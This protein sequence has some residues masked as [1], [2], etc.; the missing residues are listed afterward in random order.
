[1]MTILFWTLLTFG[2]NTDSIFIR[3]GGNWP[4]VKKFISVA[5]SK[6]YQNWAEFLLSAMPDVDLVNLNSDDFIRYFNA[7]EKNYQRVP[8]R[9]KIDTNLFYYY[10]LPHRVSQEPLENFNAFYCDTLYE[11]IKKTKDMR[12]AVL[13]INEW[14]Y[15]KM[16]YEPTERWDQNAITTIKRGIGRCEEMSILFI[17]ALRTVCI[18]ARHTYTPWWPFT[19]SN[20]AWVEVWTEDGWHALGGGELTD[21]DQAWFSTP[22]QRAAIIKS[23]MYGNI[24]ENDKSQKLNV[25]SSASKFDNEIIDKQGNG[26]TIIN[27][28]PNY[29]DVVDLLIK[30]TKDNLPVESASVSISVYNYS[31]LA[32]VGVKKT[33]ENGCVQ[34]YVGKTDLFIYAYKDSQIG[35]YVWRS[36]NKKR[37][38]VVIDIVRREFPDTSF[39]LYTRKVTLKNQKSKYRPNTELLRKLQEEHFI[40]INSLDSLTITKLDS[41]LIRIFKDA[42]GNK[43]PLMEFY[44]KL[45]ETE[46]PIFKKYFKN[47]VQKDIVGLDTCGLYQELLAV[48]KSLNL[49]DKNISDTVVQDYL[50][51][52]RI[53]YEQL[54]YWRSELQEFFMSFRKSKL[55]GEPKVK[56]IV[57]IIFYWVKDNIKKK[58]ENSYFG[59]LMNPKD[60]YRVKSA[61]ELEQYVFVVG[62][63]RSIGIPARVKW[64][65]DAVE[66]WD[67]SWKEQSLK[68]KTEK[69]KIWI[70]LSF[71]ANGKDVTEQVE[72]YDD[73]SITRFTEMPTRL[74]PEIDTFNKRIIITLNQ[75][76]S[77]LITG[78]RNG[79]G[80]TY[81]RI[82]KVLLVN[83]TAKHKINLDVPEDIRPG[84]L[85]VREYKGLKDI[86]K[87]GI[88]GKALNQSD[89]LVII[90][91]IE[92]EASRSTLK[93]AWQDI[94]LFKGKVYL[95]AVASDKEQV[96]V[97][98]K[99][100]DIYK[101]NIYLINE[102][103]Y[104]K[105][106]IKEL[107]S[108]LYLRNGRCMFWTEGLNLHIP[109][110]IQTF[111]K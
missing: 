91:D 15:T 53:L 29:T 65:Y 8:W 89:V 22:A 75:E 70:D 61:T 98:L 80:D 23:V 69:D 33:D 30:I 14:V 54:G 82:K 104:K 13:K 18:P 96:Q 81:V 99:E 9:D 55:K 7:L 35:Y 78:W 38:T 49:V 72:Y 46:K 19:N 5:K 103:V 92:S 6:G 42:K 77:Y 59:P 94:N 39:W 4:E 83:D 40:K 43:L 11:L 106:N 85:I 50:I 21:L 108:I 79:L 71:E 66:Y 64:S 34:W 111:Q 84:D 31:S 74:E 37:D 109:K 17:K 88:N 27:S 48:A 57:D 36:S 28:T 76:P 3:A 45:P 16:K 110:L 107:P 87:I 56:N 20:H 2:I 10:I 93:N 97:F 90:F 41:Q 44:S 58:D 62:V 95:L 26:Y 102:S 51:S 68:S 47:L 60:V 52:P 63:L 32:P 25:K 86:D 1:M 73:F 12:Q 24:T 105:W 101:G 100:N 67:N